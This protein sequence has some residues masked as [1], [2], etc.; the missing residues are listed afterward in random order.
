MPVQTRTYGNEPEGLGMNKKNIDWNN[1]GLGNH[2]D[3][4]TAKRLGICVATVFA[5][6]QE[7]NIKSHREQ[8]KINWRKQPLGKM[9]DQKLADKLKVDVMTV[10][11]YRNKL[12]IMPYTDSKTYKS[13]I[14]SRMKNIMKMRKKRK[15]RIDWNTVPLGKMKDVELAEILGAS[16]LAV[17]YNRVVRGIPVCRANYDIL[18]LGIVSDRRL[19]KNLNL[20]SMT[21]CHERK[22][23]SIAPFP[24]NKYFIE[25]K[26]TNRK[27]W[28]EYL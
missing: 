2:P 22:K 5:H 28:S 16:P 18:P 21:L 24:R 8:S 7:M 13:K 14:K 27:K 15:T 23:R 4:I 25:Y 1:A 20:N 6:R 3:W 10:H 9:S 26:E 17:R 11:R 12:G 19:A